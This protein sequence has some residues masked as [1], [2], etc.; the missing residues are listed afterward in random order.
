[1]PPPPEYALRLTADPPL[2]LQ[3]RTPIPFQ[4]S[5]PPLA[6]TP[7][8]SVGWEAADTTR[9]LPPLDGVLNAWVVLPTVMEYQVLRFQE[10]AL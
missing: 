9:P 6:E 8:W 10:D 1:M 7:L 5:V 2:T 3:S 4:I